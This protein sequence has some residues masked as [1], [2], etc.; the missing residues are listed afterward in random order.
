VFVVSCVGSGL[1]VELVTRS[2]ESYRVC[3]CVCVCVSLIVCDIETTTLR[4]SRPELGYSAEEKNEI[5]KEYPSMADVMYSDTVKC[6]EFHVMTT[7][8]HVRTHLSLQI[9]I[10]FEHRLKEFQSVLR[11]D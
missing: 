3:V 11:N 7:K 2:E 8:E 4:R 6:P 1:C 9:V 10:I 5:C